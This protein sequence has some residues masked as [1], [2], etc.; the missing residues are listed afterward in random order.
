MLRRVQWRVKETSVS[1]NSGFWSTRNQFFGALA[2]V[3]ALKC[4]A[5]WQLKDQPLL[6]PDAGLDT[7]AY[8]HLAQQVL[9][10]NIG[11]GPGLYYVSPFY[12]YFLAAILAVAHSFTIVRV[13]QIALGTIAV[14]AIWLMAREWFG[15]R[16]A[17]W[18]AALAA[19]TGLF[20]FYE[21][22]ILQSSIDVFLTS[23]ALCAL[24]F[25]LTRHRLSLFV[26]SGVVFG[27]MALNRPNVLLA[28]L[29]IGATLALLRRMRPM[30]LLL[31]GLVIGMSP[32][33]IR[34][35][36]V[37]HELTFV[38]SHGGLNFYIG[39]HPG[40]SGFYQQP[41]GISPT[42]E[43][44]QSD[45]I[46]VASEALGRPVTDSEADDYFYRLAWTWIRQ[47][48]VDAAAAFARKLYYTFNAGFTA[49][50]YSYPFYVH[51]ER[52][53]FRFLI[54]GPW[55][56]IPLGLVGLVSCR[57]R[58]DLSGP[59][60]NA[61]PERRGLQHRY[62]VWVAF[63]P[64]YGVAVAAFF[65]A[66]RYRLPVLVPLTVGAGATVDLLAGAISTHRLSKLFVPAIVLALLAVAADWPLGLDDGRWQ[67]GLRLA[68]RLVI[69][70]RG[71]EAA[72]VATRISPREPHPGA[73]DYGVA[74]QMLQMSEPDQA[75][76]HLEKAHQQN[77]GDAVADYALGQALLALGRPKEAIP[78]LAR[79]FNAGIEV[80]QGG[81]DYA[82]ALRDAGDIGGALSV[83]RRINAGDDPEAWLRLGRFAAEARAPDVAEPFF[84]RAV[85]LH[86]DAASHQQ[87]GVDLL[88]LQKY[89]EAARELADANR[90]DPRNTDTLSHLAYAEAKLGRLDQARAHT[91]QAL[92]L[93]PNDALARQLA[94]ALR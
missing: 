9:G 62:L 94:A 84:R 58:A 40:A 1:R 60:R 2:A 37:S 6:Q 52:T 49:L 48:P 85:A 5:L 66:D 26:A 77:P 24:T 29:A 28:S 61:G 42:I 8:A 16:A 51:D 53:L 87:L 93:D 91:S 55:L 38:S 21:I 57:C 65:V 33:A 39:N 90:L 56:L 81:Y 3:F 41:P 46:R 88:L 50:P 68:Q 20:T 35:V 11:L 79:G 67:E 7:T 73:T 47:H 70:G 23:A 71:A 69:L 25:A 74:A 10:G 80:P 18:A 31:A 75:L 15:D 30:A 54:I 34:N 12:I 78:H 64:A 82:L 92:A 14:G 45:T 43:G 19:F 22:L 63:V 4:A 59:P 83:L 13:V 44:Q 17:W 32:A 27:V 76:P 36:V 89:D 72:D 86:P